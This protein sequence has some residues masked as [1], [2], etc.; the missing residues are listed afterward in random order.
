[1]SFAETGPAQM[2][3]AQRIVVRLPQG[4]LLKNLLMLFSCR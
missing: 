3:Q 1:M 2:T 4:S